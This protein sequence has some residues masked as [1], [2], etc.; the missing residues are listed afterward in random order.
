MSL[1]DEDG[2]EMIREQSSINALKKM[3]GAQQ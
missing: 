3:R 2:F 1:V